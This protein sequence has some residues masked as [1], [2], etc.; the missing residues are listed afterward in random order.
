MKTRAAVMWEAGKPWDV[1]ELELDPPKAGE[2]LIKFTASGLCHSDDHART[3]DLPGN[4]PLVGGHEG[5]PADTRH[6]AFCGIAAKEAERAMIPTAG[7]RSQLIV[8]NCDAPA[9][10]RN[11]ERPWAGL[12]PSSRT[13]WRM[14]KG[15]GGYPGP[16]DA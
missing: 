16:L 8:F 15:T 12:L 10:P 4:Y 13:S 7:W 14:A 1:V 6:V 3:G 9:L 11:V 2:V 5:F